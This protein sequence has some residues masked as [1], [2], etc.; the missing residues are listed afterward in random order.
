[1]VFSVIIKFVLKD[2]FVMLKL[3]FSSLALLTFSTLTASHDVA[4]AMF[5]DEGMPSFPKRPAVESKLNAFQGENRPSFPKRSGV[6]PQSRFQLQLGILEEVEE[7]QTKPTRTNKTLSTERK[8]K[9]SSKNDKK[10]HGT[11][12]KK[13]E[14]DPK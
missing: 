13:N 7:E 10:P 1:M 5:K 6:E 3:S 11:K 9:T 4:C 14:V 8:K 12:V 2:I